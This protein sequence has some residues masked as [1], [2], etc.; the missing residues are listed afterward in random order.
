VHMKLYNSLSKKLEILQ[1]DGDVKFY[2]CGITPYDTTHLGH[3]FTYIVSDVLIRFLE[4]K[5]HKVI[6]VQ[7]VTDID[8]DILSKA[9]KVGEDWYALGNRWTRHFIEDMKN[10][11]VR[12]PDHYPR[13]TEVIPSMVNIIEKL[14]QNG[15]AYQEGSNVYFS[16]ESWSEYGK[17]SRLSKD[18]MLP[19]A[20]QRGNKPEDPNK[21]S[22]LDFPLWQAQ[23]GDEP[24]W[25]SPW[26]AGRPGWHIECS[27]MA[28][29]L[30]GNKIDIHSGGEDLIFPHHECEI[31]QVE[32]LT[33]DEPFVRFWLH[34]AM[35][36]HRGE[37]MSKSLGNL[38][39]I[40][41]LLM[42]WPADA[43]RIYLAMHHYRSPWSHQMTELERAANITAQIKKAVTLKSGKKQKLDPTPFQHLFNIALERDLDTPAAIEQVAKLADEIL[44][45]SQ[46]GGDILE[47]QQVLRACGHILGLRLDANTPD[48]GVLKGWDEHLIKFQ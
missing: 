46:S 48:P 31:A 25:R 2:T 7:N 19:I 15:V 18:E 23:T 5:G 43:V 44:A 34:V 8:D 16:I 35:V 17:L 42:T 32:P 21:R 29:K 12:P 36:R 9:R 39:M 38:V 13:A 10:L 28:T 47:S 33:G 4:S 6:Y 24:A 41:D 30:L 37:K 11:N 40:N 22:P 27:T 14:L 20:N 1:P 3:A 45:V 26:G